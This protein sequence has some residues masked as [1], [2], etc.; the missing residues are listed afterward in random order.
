MPGQTPAQTA[1][2]LAAPARR[3]TPRLTALA[4]P[5]LAC[6]LLAGCADRLTQEAIDDLGTGLNAQV[7]AISGFD[8][9]G[10]FADAEPAPRL[11]SALDAIEG[12]AAPSI[13]PSDRHYIARTAAWALSEG[14]PGETYRWQSTVT[15]HQ[16]FARASGN[17]RSNCR[18]L[19]LSFQD[20]LGYT[21]RGHTTACRLSD[22]S[23]R[24]AGPKPGAAELQ[25]LY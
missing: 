12:S 17:P 20:A 25:A 18:R 16:G 5:A 4:A 22:G 24:L 1:R 7:A 2:P 21:A 14:A 10:V 23:W 3:H 19:L 6:L 13:T 9:T 8:Y 11:V 15:G